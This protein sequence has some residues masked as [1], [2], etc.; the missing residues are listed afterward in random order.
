MANSFSAKKRIKQNEERRGRNRARKRELKSEI[1]KFTE[2]LHDKDQDA[3]RSQYRV[4]VKKL[5]QTAAK[6]TLHKNAAART[7]SRLAKRL[8]QLSAAG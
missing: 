6:G 1:R 3:A 7:K 8:N 2:A 4:V 5:D